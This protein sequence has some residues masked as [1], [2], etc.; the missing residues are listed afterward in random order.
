MIQRLQ[1]GTPAHEAIELSERLRA[2]GVPASEVFHVFRL[3]WWNQYT[4]LFPGG[5]DKQ[6][7]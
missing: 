3:T 4:K 2:S 7:N 1:R 6:L 5:N